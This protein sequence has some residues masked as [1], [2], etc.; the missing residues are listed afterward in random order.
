MSQSLL[1]DRHGTLHRHLHDP[2]SLTHKSLSR[3]R[4]GRLHYD[5]RA[6]RMMS[7]EETVTLKSVQV[8]QCGPSPGVSEPEREKANTDIQDGNLPS[9]RPTWRS[10]TAFTSG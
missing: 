1:K 4:V 8:R 7:P 3:R 6:T 5:P 10:S 2:L 9:A